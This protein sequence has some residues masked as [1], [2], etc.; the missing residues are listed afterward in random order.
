M[1]ALTFDVTHTLLHSPRLGDIYSEILNRHGIAVDP[2]EALRL[3]GVVWQE[4][5]CSA[6]PGRDRFSSHPEGARGFWERFLTR[7]TEHLGSP[8]ATRF[9][10]AELFHRFGTASAWEV[11]PEV[12]EVLAELRRSG[13]KLGIVSN[14]DPRLP[15]LLAELEL[16]PYFDAIV[17]SA[18]V[19]VEKPDRRIFARAIADLGVDPGAVLHVGDSQIEDVEGAMA[20]GMRAVRV[21]RTDRGKPGR[22]RRAVHPPG[23]LPVPLPDLSTLPEMV[24]AGRLRRG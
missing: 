23:G 2:V 1:E 8:P 17:Y 21:V 13:F 12:R 6:D 20:A 10:A 15:E 16:A 22:A 5:A 9:A 7:F 3:I 11:Y 19:G 14:W 4:M 18:K 24:A